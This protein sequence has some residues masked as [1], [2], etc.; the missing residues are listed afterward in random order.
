MNQTLLFA[1][2][3]LLVLLFCVQTVRLHRRER[4]M[5]KLA[6]K[7][8][9]HER[10]IAL[11]RLLAGIAHEMNTPLGAV[12]C[13]LNT[14]RRAMSK[15]Q[16]VLAEFT[17][18]DLADKLSPILSAAEATDPVLDEALGRLR[19]L[20]GQLRQAMQPDSVNLDALLDSQPMVCGGE[21]IPCCDSDDPTPGEMVQVNEVI[22]GSLLLLRHELKQ[23][24]EVDLQLTDV[25][26]VRGWRGAVG[27]V[28]LN[29]LVNARQAIGDSGRI[30]VSTS[31]DQDQVCVTIAD[32]GC[33]LPV[34]VGDQIFEPHFTT[35]AEDEGTGLGLFISRM[36]VRAHGGTISAENRPD[37]GAVFTV[38][39]PVATEDLN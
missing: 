4:H 24:V 22:E 28:V 16:G 27:Q 34:G 10:M 17:D 26:P 18:T 35:K 12:D 30:I 9:H 8:V 21:R 14:R 7:M 3:I 23:G 32:T 33:G 29:L 15:I 37:C 11:G 20:V 6:V 2:L 36:I 25:S 5:A 13:S 31:Q 38:C 1:G 19:G 39:L